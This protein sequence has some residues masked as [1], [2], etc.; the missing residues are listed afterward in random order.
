V[1][2]DSVSSNR[3]KAQNIVS[4]DQFE[5]DLQSQ[6][7]PQ[8]VRDVSLR[9]RFPADNEIQMHI[10]PNMSNDGHDTGLE[11]GTAW[12]RSFLNPL[13]Q[14]SYFTKRT[15]TLLTLD[16]TATYDEPNK[17]ASLLL[18]DIPEDLKGTTD[19][20]FY[21]HYSA[22]ATVE[23]NWNL[24]NLGRYDVGANVFQLVANTTRYKNQKNVD[25]AKIYLNQSYPGYLSSSHNISI[26]P[27]NVDLIG[28]GSQGVLGSIASALVNG[29]NCGSFSTPYDGSG[30]VFEAFSPPQYQTV[31][32]NPE[33]GRTSTPCTANSPST[34]AKTAGSIPKH[35]RANLHRTLLSMTAVLWALA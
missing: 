11:Y 30:M 34:P 14:N 13:L 22:L 20:T 1:S 16:E 9:T 33:A 32:V 21:T 8:W 15:L 10:S 5:I 23:N 4:L 25:T 17:V 18:G 31:Q 7:L 3:S 24:P 26:P 2:F 35:S 6:S 12:S 27:P 28:S 19:D 29:T